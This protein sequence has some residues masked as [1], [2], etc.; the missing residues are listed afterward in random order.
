MDQLEAPVRDCMV[1][2]VQTLSDQLSLAEAARELQ[3]LGM[4]AMP[5]LDCS[6]GLVGALGWSELRGAAKLLSRVEEPRGQ[7]RLP[8]GCVVQFMSS[9]VPLIAPGASVALAA[10]R[11]YERGL[12][13]LYVVAEGQLEGVLS[14]RELLRVVL[15]APLRMPLGKLAR[16]SVATIDASEPLAVATALWSA[17]PQ[18]GGRRFAEP[19]LGAR[20]NAEPLSIIITRDG[21]P[22]GVLT[23]EA[24][25][26]TREADPR[27]GV[28]GWM[29]RALLSLPAELPASRGAQALLEQN[30]RYIITRG[31]TGG[32]GLVSGLDFARLIAES[33]APGASF[34]H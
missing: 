24:A 18:H 13:R 4:S 10:R 34:D 3:Q 11:M 26:L 19:A 29:D 27:E 21:Q 1:S 14:T 9:R 20:R 16:R 32:F 31:A 5:V 33:A 12:K 7:L 28:D 8:A 2:S 30:Q 17:E 6:G 22:V 23:P 25:A 15:N